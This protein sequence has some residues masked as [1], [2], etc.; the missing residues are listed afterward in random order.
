M[1]NID[2]ATKLPRLSDNIYF[3]FIVFN[4]CRLFCL[5][6]D[7][8]VHD[9]R[10]RSVFTAQQ[11]TALKGYIVEMQSRGFGLTIL[12]C[13]S[14]VFD[15]AEANHIKHSFD[16]VSKM[17]GVD[18]LTSF[19]ETHGI[20]LR[21]PEATSI[22]RAMGFNKEDV[23]KFYGILE[24]VRSTQAFAPSH[25]SNVDESRLSTVPTR[26]PK[27]LSP[28]GAKRVAKGVSAER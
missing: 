14:L 23:G 12:Q 25:I 10:F 26:L 28:C 27:V 15:Y 18:W 4:K 22:S 9:G 8:A 20:T 7:F 13:R 16:I 21:A 2:Y 24:E 17:A 1:I 6:H 19:R 11:L 5:L 3:I